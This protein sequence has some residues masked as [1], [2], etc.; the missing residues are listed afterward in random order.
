MDEQERR[1]REA[2]SSQAVHWLSGRSD[3]GAQP[4]DQPDDY[5]YQTQ[6]GDC[7]LHWGYISRISQYMPDYIHPLPSFPLHLTP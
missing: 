6:Q 5:E 7:H 2:A 1:V 4:A 3:V